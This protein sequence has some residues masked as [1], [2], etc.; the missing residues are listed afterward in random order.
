MIVQE[1]CIAMGNL[2]SSTLMELKLS[3]LKTKKTYLQESMAARLSSTTAE[4]RSTI[5]SSLMSEVGSQ[6]A[7][8]DNGAVIGFVSALFNMAD[9]VERLAKEVEDLKDIAS[10]SK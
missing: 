9:K 10:F 7:M 1:P 4:L 2:L 5:S 8:V 6:N 3:L